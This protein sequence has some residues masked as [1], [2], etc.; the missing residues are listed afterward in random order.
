MLPPFAS[1]ANPVDVTPVWSRFA[2]LYPALTDLLARSGEVDVVVPVLLQRAALDATTAE[3]LRDVVAGL[4]ADGVACRCTCAGWRPATRA[5][6]ADLL[7]G[8]GRAVL[9]L[10]RPHRPRDRARP[11]LRRGSRPHD[12]RRRRGPV[13]AVGRYAA[14]TRWRGAEL[15]AELGVDTAPS[16]LCRT[17]D[18]AVAAATAFPVVVKLAEAAHRT[19]LGGVRARPRRRRRGARRGGG[20]AGTGP[21]AGAA[22]AVRGGDRHRGRARPGVRAGRD[23]RAR[24]DLGRGA[25]RR[26][27]RHG[28]AAPRRGPLVAGVAARRRA[29]HRG[30]RRPAVDLDALA[31]VVVAAGNLLLACP[32]VVELDLNPVLATADSAVAVDWKIWGGTPLSRIRDRNQR[33]RHGVDSDGAAGG[34]LHPGSAHLRVLPR[35][36]PARRAAAAVPARGAR[37]GRQV[38]LRHRRPR[39]GR[40]GVRAGGRV[41]LGGARAAAADGLRVHLPVRRVLRD[42]EDDRLLGPRDGRGGGGPGLRLRAGRGRDDLGAA[43]ASPA[44]TC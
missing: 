34:E 28:A 3:G 7:P 22:A 23:G 32:D 17:A 41:R 39:G 8:R 35:P 10:A 27:V 36:E 6:N 37:R 18:E 42:R 2:E 19:E 29:A 25:R 30:P 13:G 4:R 44:R 16:T 33:L 20:P 14:P 5:P 26:R 11:P 1:P 43:R 12:A 31:D 21:G 40:G 24:R 9:R 38:H 15:L